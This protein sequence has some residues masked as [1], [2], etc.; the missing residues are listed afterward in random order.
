M[1][2]IGL[3][4]ERE[5]HGERERG[6]VRCWVGNNN[7]GERVVVV[8]SAR[9]EGRKTIT[10]KQGRAERLVSLPPS[11]WLVALARGTRGGELG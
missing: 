7:D 8:E 9:E 1:A 4:R 11:L 10:S 2:L 3:M 6:V 5:G